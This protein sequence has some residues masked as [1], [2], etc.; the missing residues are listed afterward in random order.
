MARPTNRPTM[1]DL[2]A[3]ASLISQA[4]ARLTPPSAAFDPD[5]DWTH[6]YHDISS[7]GLKHLQGE[8]TVRHKSGG[9][10]MIENHRNC[11]NSYRSYTLAELQCASDSLSTP[12][13]WRVE[14]KVAKQLKGSPYMNSGIVKLASV[15][16]GVLTM[17]TGRSKATIKLPG[18]YTCKWCLL[19]AVGRMAKEGAT[20]ISF[21]ML[22]EYDEPC[23][24]QQLAFREKRKVETRSGSIEVTC[25][26]HTGTG[27]MPGM[28]YVDTHGRVLIY[29]AG[30]QLLALAD[31]DG[32]KTGYMK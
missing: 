24:D 7:F 11:P 9:Q 31:A 28:F 30:M 17:H 15:K 32:T 14:S 1:Q 20:D 27:T 16:D 22:D 5:G 18:A 2:S 21:T 25:Y 12:S 6:V 13:T 26:Q 10:L 4:F 19:D 3:S 29:L 8:L 23:P